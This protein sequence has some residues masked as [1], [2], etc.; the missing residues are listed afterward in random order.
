MV[1]RSGSMPYTCEPKAAPRRPKPHTTSSAMSRMSY[2]RSTF[3]ISSQYPAG[4]GM[5][6]PVPSTGSPMKAAMVSG[7][8]RVISPSSFLAQMRGELALVDA[9]FR[10]PEVMRRHRVQHRPLRQVERVVVVVEA[11]E[12][13]R[14]DGAAVIAAPARDDLL[15]VRAPEDVVVVPDDLELGLVGIR[16]REAELDALH[17]GRGHVEHAPAEADGGL[18]RIAAERVVVRE[19]QRLLMDGVRDLAAAIAHV[20]AVDARKGVD[21]LLAVAQLDAD[22]LPARHDAGLARLPGGELA[23][24][25]ERMEQRR[26]VEGLEFSGGGSEGSKSW[27]AREVEG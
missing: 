18:V 17:A 5:M 6:P 11:G 26:P 14:H 10:V 3:W 23:Q 25:R 4:G 9:R 22:A 2:F 21:E 12:A 8:S 24:R 27:A 20:V 1:I 7:P 16:A 19:L 15:L 13:A